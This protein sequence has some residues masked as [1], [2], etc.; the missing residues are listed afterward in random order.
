MDDK[1]ANAVAL[2]KREKYDKTNYCSDKNFQRR[3]FMKR[4]YIS[5]FSLSTC[6]NFFFSSDIT[7]EEE[8]FQRA[9]K[10]LPRG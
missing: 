5:K 9:E 7:S 8:N 1:H 2:Y 6:V 4:F 10:N 3:D